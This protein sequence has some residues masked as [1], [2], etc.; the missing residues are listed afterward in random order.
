[1]NARTGQGICNDY[2]TVVNQCAQREII[3]HYGIAMRLETIVSFAGIRSSS[4][5]FK[6]SDRRQAAL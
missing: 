3:C 5:A 1:M 6:H 2:P 4:I